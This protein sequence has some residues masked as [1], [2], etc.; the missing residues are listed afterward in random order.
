MREAR[1]LRYFRGREVR[2]RAPRV[3]SG[4]ALALALTLALTARSARGQTIDASWLDQL[5]WRPL[6]P[7]TFGGRIVDI[8]LVPG[9]PFGMLVASA[10]GGLF[11][12]RNNGTT[13]ESI[14]EDQPVVSIGAIA[15]DPER[16]EVIWVGTGEANNQRSSYW[17]DGVYK[18]EDGGK[19]W[20]NVGLAGTHHIA[21][22]AIDPKD[23]NTVWVATLGRL[24]SPNPER[25]LYRTSDGGGSWTHSL[26]LG[27]TIGVTDV[28]VDPETPDVVYAASYERLRR[29]WHFDGAGPGAGIHRS[30]DRGASWTRLACGLPEGELDRI[31]LAL[32]E[33]APGMLYAAISNQNPRPE[34]RKTDAGY[35][36][37]FEADGLRITS[38][39]E[40]STA[41]EAGLAVGDV[42]RAVD[43]EPIADVWSYVRAI[44][45]KGESER[46]TLS[47]KRGD[48]ELEIAFELEVRESKD[49][50]RE[51]VGGEVWRSADGGL[52]WEKRNEKPVSGEPPYYY[53]QIRVDPADPERLF[54]L[55][56]PLYH[57]EDGG[58]T[59]KSDGAR[60]VHVDHHAFVFDPAHPGRVVLGN[61]GGLA[62]SFDGGATW[63]H[64]DNL[65]IA[66]FYAIG[67]DM[68]RP[69]HVFGGTQDNGTWGA[70]SRRAGGIGAEDWYPIGGGDGFYAQVDPRDHLT[71]YGESQ[72]DSLYRYDLATGRTTSIQPSAGEGDSEYRFN[73]NSP[74]LLSHHNS[75]IVYFGGNRLFKSYDRGDSWPVVSPDL[76][77]ADPAKIAGNVPHC[78]ITTIAESPIDPNLLL[79]G[80]DDGLVQRSSD[81]GLTWTNLTGRFPGA[82]AGWWVSRVELSAHSR[83]V[84]YVSFTGYREDDFRPMLFR[85]EDAGDNWTSIVGDLPAEPINV[86]REDPVEAAVLWTGTESGVHLTFDR[87]QHWTRLRKGLPTLPVHDLVVHPR[88][89]EV[90]IGT[91]GRGMYVLEASLLQELSADVLA[92]PVHLYDVVDVTLLERGAGRGWQGDRNWRASNPEVGAWI[93]YHLLEEAAEGTLRVVIEE[94]SGAEVRE[95][96]VPREAGLHRVRWD[97]RRER[98]GEEGE[99]RGGQRAGEGK[100]SA[101][102]RLGEE[103]QRKSF[104]LV[105]TSDE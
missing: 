90:V 49:S 40:G 48:Q 53:G 52:T 56:V 94:E 100:Y 68:R 74:I 9:E 81:G 44:G 43:G 27:P 58:K 89:R 87:G 18:S 79:V 92:R 78:T 104:R 3:R 59:W 36:G 42:V 32:H 38:V 7:S 64:Y 82:E 67:V 22:I 47:V 97:L 1:D 12:T 96:D 65:P 77:T 99:R 70:P 66:Q 84:A 72:F 45:R 39:T 24:Y 35:Q 93:A 6:G 75:E 60:S 13:W 50:P 71:V 30:V 95:L 34:A 88:D 29:P 26:D 98:T 54:L 28:V 69:Y 73:W 86:V 103:E 101:V 80:S 15:I 63:D 21:R 37:A 33:G 51:E 8:A 5:A 76:T 41:A 61:D 102:L 11:R 57:S 85:S 31:G 2:R 4:F 14:F 105:P 62:Q 25:G 20:R 46:A 55:G 23:T 10:S 17:G 83:D 16:P 91:H 19:S